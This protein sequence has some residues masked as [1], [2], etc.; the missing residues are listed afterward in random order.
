VADTLKK[1]DKG[2]DTHSSKNIGIPIAVGRLIELMDNKRVD[3]NTEEIRLL[4]KAEP[5]FDPHRDMNIKSLRFG[6]SEEVDYGRGSKTIKKEKR[7]NDLVLTF[8]GKGNGLSDKNFT[9]KLLGKTKKGDLLFGFARLPWLDYNLPILSSL[10]PEF[11]LNSK[12]LKTELEI[13]NSGQVSSN[14]TKVTIEYLKDDKWI[15]VNEGKVPALKP[16][17]KVSLVFWGEKFKERNQVAQVRVIIQQEDSEPAIL[18]G[19]VIIR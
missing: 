16:Y 19:P 3:E 4:I 1:Q 7:G 10:F 5:G 9:A 14:P 13:E 15:L 2:S 11:T 6:A 17:E 12:S 18:E 8:G